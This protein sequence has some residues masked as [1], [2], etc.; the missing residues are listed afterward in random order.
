MFWNKKYGNW[1]FYYLLFCFDLIILFYSNFYT[2]SLQ[3]RQK[4]ITGTPLW[5]RSSSNMQVCDKHFC[6]VTLEFKNNFVP[7]DSCTIKGV[8]IENIYMKFTSLT[9]VPTGS[10]YK[11]DRRLPKKYQIINFSSPNYWKSSIGGLGWN[12]S[13][14]V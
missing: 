4:N 13:G 6:P 14:L 9:W 1:I 2:N 5:N 11:V 10:L 8:M 3:T 7:L 12:G